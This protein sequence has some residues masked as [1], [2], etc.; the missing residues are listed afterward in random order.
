MGENIPKP[1]IIARHEFINELTSVINKYHLPVFI[2]ES[3]LKDFYMD[4]KDIS[5]KQLANELAQYNQAIKNAAH[6]EKKMV[7]IEDGVQND[8]EEV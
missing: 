6:E 2:V 5:N 1:L 7:V 4:I 8:R 3:I